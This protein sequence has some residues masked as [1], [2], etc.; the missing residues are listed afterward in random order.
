[1]L[2]HTVFMK[3]QVVI[4]TPQ[5][6]TLKCLSDTLWSCRFDSFR[7]IKVSLAALIS[8]LAVIIEEE[9]NGSVVCEA[10]GILVNIKK[11][12]FILAFYVLLDLL[13]HNKT[14]SYF[15]QRKDLDFVSTRDMIYLQEILQKKRSESAFDDCFVE[16][17][18]KCAALEIEEPLLVP[19]R[20]RVSTRY[21]RTNFIT[22]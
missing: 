2:R 16:A 17:K 22:N 7:A 15:L 13:M 5:P 6:V 10:R 1:M 4:N 18:L 3:A 9:N 8:A 19:K 21:L 20:R 14:L 12:E 11:L